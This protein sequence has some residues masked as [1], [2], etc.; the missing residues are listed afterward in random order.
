MIVLDHHIV[1]S[2]HRDDAA[3]WLTDM[4]G[5]PA[6]RREGPF[7]AVDLGAATSLFFAGWDQEVTAQHYAFAV[8]PDEFERIVQRLVAGEVE[9][10]AEHDLR[11]P[12]TVRRDATGCGVYFRSPDGHLLEL[13]THRGRTS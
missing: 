4:L 12:A 13:L 3:R 8:G 10:F 5:L 7:A 1:P 6:P 2:R 11:E 9:H